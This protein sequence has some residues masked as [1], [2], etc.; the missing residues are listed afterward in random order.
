MARFNRIWQSNTISFTSKFKLYESPVTS[1]LWLWDMDPACWL[2]RQGSRLSKS[3]AWGNFSTSRT[4]STRLTT[5]CRSRSTPLWAQRNLFLQLSRDGNSH[6]QTCHMLWQPLQNH[7]SGQS[8]VWAMLWSA[9][10]MLDGQH[11]SLPV[12]ELLTMTSSGKDSAEL[13]I[14]SSRQSNWPRDWIE[15]NYVN[16]NFCKYRWRD[17]NSWSAE[18][19]GVRGG[20]SVATGLNIVRAEPWWSQRTVI[21]ALDSSAHA[22]ASTVLVVSEDC[23]L[24][25]GQFRSCCSIYC[26]SKWPR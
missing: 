14:M 22:A 12:P 23:S 4:W 2:L 1:P 21:C 13:S 10:E 19:T 26:C 5:G 6:I 15:L 3:S 8:G 16:G 24:C 20:R 18:Q 25:S 11:Q 9:E 7:P 17:F